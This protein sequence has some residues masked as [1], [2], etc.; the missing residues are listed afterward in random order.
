M[1]ATGSHHLRSELQV[2]DNDR[3]TFLRVFQLC[4]EGDKGYL[5]REDLKVAV[6][7]LFGYKPS[8]LE[9]D[10]MLSSFMINSPEGITSDS[11][12][13]MMALKKAAQLSFGNQREIFSVFDVHC[14]GFLTLEDFKRAFR[15]VAPHL[16]ERTVVEAFREVDQDSDG[17]VSYKDFEFVLNYGEDG[18]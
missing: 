5:S 6:V 17:L 15:Q 8:K 4:D 18:E 9:V 11:F 16:S 2:N 3:K 12:L 13:K 10:S 1:F 14:R 7:M